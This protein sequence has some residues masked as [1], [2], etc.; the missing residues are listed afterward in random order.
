M[1]SYKETP[2]T[3]PHATVFHVKPKDLE[4]RQLVVMMQL[5]LVMIGGVISLVYNEHPHTNFSRSC[6]I[7]QGI[8][9]ICDK[10]QSLVSITENN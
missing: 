3:I 9:G 1:I 6:F 2:I 4:Y 5:P 7:I 10:V 8:L